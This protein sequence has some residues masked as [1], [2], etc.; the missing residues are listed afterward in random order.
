MSDAPKLAT[1]PSL[2]DRV[3]LVTGGGSGIG[4]AIVEGF[5]RNGAKV[6]FLDIDIAAS[7]ALVDRLSGARHRPR[8]ERCDLTDN[9]ALRST[10][11]AI[12]ASLGDIEVLVNNAA[13]DK[14]HDIET[15][16]PEEWDASEAINI[17]QQFFAAQAVLP[18]MKAK[19]AGSIINLS[20]VAWMF[21]AADMIAY[22]T[23]KSAVIGLTRS[24]ATELG[25]HGI[26][27][28]AIAPGAVMTEKQLRLW[29]T[30]ESTARLMGMQAIKRSLGEEEIASAALFLAADDSRM[31][32]KQC[33]TVD[34]GLR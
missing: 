23:A 26:R 17:K 21:G 34:G 4:A 22:V 33:L 1:Y 13:N 24:L 10:I 14:R 32:T 25:K 30:P 8:F 28:N 2:V 15:I 3:V 5:A 27:V 11:A 9:P 31:I 12:T 16:T 18:G 20:S 29:H 7:Q 6:A 19:G